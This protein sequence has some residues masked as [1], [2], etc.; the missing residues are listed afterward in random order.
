VNI[1]LLMK[2][3][4]QFKCNENFGDTG[5]SNYTKNLIELTKE[6]Y[7]KVYRK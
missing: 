6:D 2:L 3:E 7:P 5:L 4:K 1:E